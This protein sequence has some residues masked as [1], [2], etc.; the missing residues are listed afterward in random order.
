MRWTTTNMQ[1]ERNIHS[2]A[3]E[4]QMSAKLNLI[5]G[6]LELCYFK[7]KAV[8]VLRKKK[9]IVRRRT[10]FPLKFPLSFIRKLQN[11]IFN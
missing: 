8:F 3:F 7:L 6:S 2:R 9:N 10:F 4:K 1:N 11:T 5:G